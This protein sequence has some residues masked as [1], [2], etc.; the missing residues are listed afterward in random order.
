MV[1]LAGQRAH[2]LCLEQAAVPAC[3]GCGA[4]CFSQLTE[5]VR[6]DGKDYA[7]IAE[8]A[9]ELT[10]FEGN[11]CYM[12]MHEGHCAA[13]LLDLSTR[14]FVCSI[15]EQRPE[16]CRELARASAQCS[17]EIHEKGERPLMLLHRQEARGLVK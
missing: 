6:V 15:Y 14:R 11:R 7:R 12:R 5:Y 1:A 13:L 2:N 16:I 17:A 9:D 4:C 10:V 3:L 8:L